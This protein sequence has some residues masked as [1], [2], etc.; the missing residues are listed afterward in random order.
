MGSRGYFPAVPYGAQADTAFGRPFGG[1]ELGL[2]D[3][4]ITSTTR[5]WSRRRTMT[6]THVFSLHQNEHVSPEQDRVARRLVVACAVLL[7]P[8]RLVRR[9]EGRATLPTSPSG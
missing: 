4:R 3:A 6:T 9:R 1:S 7:V 8:R 2:L 5:S